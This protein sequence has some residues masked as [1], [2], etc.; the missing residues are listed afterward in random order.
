MAKEFAK[1][2]ESD[3]HF[4]KKLEQLNKT[5]AKDVKVLRGKNK[6]F[7]AVVACTVFGICILFF[8][9]LILA[10]TIIGHINDIYHVY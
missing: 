6:I 9:R 2:S 1:L 7:G 8:A 3:Q 5:R 4:V 10:W